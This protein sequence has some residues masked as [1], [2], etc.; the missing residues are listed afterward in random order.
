MRLLE[1]GRV[2]GLNADGSLHFGVRLPQGQCA[3]VSREANA[4]LNQSK[5]CA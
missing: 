4:N 1:S 3:A 2:G 5:L